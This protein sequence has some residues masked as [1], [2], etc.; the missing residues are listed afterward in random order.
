MR[1]IIAIILLLLESSAVVPHFD[2]TL[3][4]VTN[5]DAHSAD[6]ALQLLRSLRAAEGKTNQLKAHACYSKS[7]SNDH[8]KHGNNNCSSTDEYCSKNSSDDSMKSID[9]ILLSESHRK[10]FEY[11]QVEVHD[12][13][14]N[15]KYQE[16]SDWLN[17]QCA[18]K[19][20]VFI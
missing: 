12:N 13:L 5:F 11:L 18:I 20:S 7:S 4:V 6:R 15:E 9:N 16:D 8:F 3:A 2:S 10:Q 1:L 19:V 14:Y 17:L